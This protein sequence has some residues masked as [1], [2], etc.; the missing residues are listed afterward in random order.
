M[1]DAIKRP[2]WSFVALLALPC[3]IADASAQVA[4]CDALAAS[5][6][7]WSRPAAVAG[8]NLAELD[9]AK[10]V[11]A[12]RKA[13]NERPDDPRIK[14]Q[15][16]RALSKTDEPPHTYARLYR[17][18]AEHGSVGAAHNLGTLYVEGKGVAQDVGEANRWYRKAAEAGDTD[19]MHLLAHNLETGNGIARDDAAALAW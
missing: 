17:E 4:D 15:L 13:L 5:P 7:D 10:A 8:V 19:A 16:A 18:A 3:F 14:F 12:C 6:F 1:R 9:A 11:P 2:A